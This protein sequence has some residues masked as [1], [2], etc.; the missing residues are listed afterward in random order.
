MN[1]VEEFG[2]KKV[3]LI[4]PRSYDSRVSPP[5]GLGLIASY[6]KKMECLQPKI[7]DLNI[8]TDD[9]LFNYISLNIDDI[10]YVAISTVSMTFLDVINLVT[11][12][13][14]SFPDIIVVLGGIYPSFAYREILS[15][16]ACVDYITVGE[17]EKCS[18]ELGKALCKKNDVSSIKGV[19]WRNPDGIPILNKC[20]DTRCAAYNHIPIDYAV[21]D[22]LRYFIKKK[23]VKTLYLLTSRGCPFN[24][25]F[26]TNYNY[27]KLFCS[28]FR[29]RAINVIEKEVINAKNNYKIISQVIIQ[30]NDFLINEKHAQN[31]LEI[32]T[33]YCG[34]VFI[35]FCTRVDSLLRAKDWLIDY[36]D[37]IDVEIG[38]ESF[39]PSQL[40]RFNKRITNSNIKEALAFIK[41]FKIKN[42]IDMLYFE[43]F[44]TKDELK[45][46]FEKIM[47]FRLCEQCE[48]SLFLRCY[49][50]P[51]TD[52]S[53]KAVKMGLA[54]GSSFSDNWSFLNASAGVIWKYLQLFKHTL[55]RKI[56]RIR[57]RI[58]EMIIGSNSFPAKGKLLLLRYS[59]FEFCFLYANE[60]TNCDTEADYKD[61]LNKYELLYNS[62]IEQV[63]ENISSGV[64]KKI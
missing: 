42:L 56:L 37:V 29:Y 10:V 28:G 8:V 12:I 24:C 6:M 53:N 39:S 27:S 21:F 14:Y 26:C 63:Y 18:L 9:Y 51:E 58:D 43:P 60:L 7:I 34:K 3:L 46:N 49:L 13:K 41:K 2:L 11:A 35:K 59:T 64:K 4:N 48:Y 36:Y 62:E 38:I 33:K 57:T 15:S 1:I 50:Y 30:D 61:I 17:G 45:V 16:Y 23:G 52:I 40:V 54:T 31:V 55:Y 5:L 44:V 47:E 22:N 19:A 25:A 32:I 20:A